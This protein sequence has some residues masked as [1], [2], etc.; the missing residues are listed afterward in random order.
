M[1]HCS[2]HMNV[3]VDDVIAK[4][5]R[6]GLS[7]DESLIYIELLRGPSNHTRLSHA[8]G[9]NRTKVYRI[10]ETLEKTGLISKRA[11]DRG[12]ALAAN[13]LSGLELHLIEAED[14][15][16]RQRNTITELQ[17]QLSMLRS[18]N[19][20]EFFINTYE[21]VNGF[22]Q[23]TWNELRTEGET[24][25]FGN[26][27]IEELVSD[28]EWACR[29]RQRQLEAGYKIREITNYRYETNQ[30]NFFTAKNIEETGLYRHR[31]IS[32]HVIAFDGQTVVYNSTV[33]I[34]HWKHE[35]KIGVEIICANY[36]N[37]MRQMFEQYW[38]MAKES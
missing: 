14:Q 7:R 1:L 34:Y 18:Y 25:A 21:G 6:L 4:L 28:N 29:H 38:N 26:G 15:L 17:T 20:G 2:V 19:P 33:A 16:K 12:S 35:R 31:M 36:A 8:T 30:S 24:L 23:M 9:V 3:T 22:K 27:T 37:M 10:V 5:N 11:D 32:P 13:D